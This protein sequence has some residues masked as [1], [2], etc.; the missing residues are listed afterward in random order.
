M[1]MLERP[2]ADLL[3]NLGHDERVGG[4]ILQ[5]L[6]GCVV[7]LHLRVHQDVVLDLDG[8]AQADVGV[9]V[10]VRAEDEATALGDDDGFDSGHDGRLS[11]DLADVT[12]RK[13]QRLALAYHRHTIPRSDGLAFGP[14]LS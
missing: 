6:V 2:A 10:A 8:R 4:V 1:V 5:S 12:L 9:V 13:A 14:E 7:E 3:P 11:V